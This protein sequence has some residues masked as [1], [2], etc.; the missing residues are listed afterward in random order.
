[1]RS[2]YGVQQG[3]VGGRRYEQRMNVVARMIREK[4][5]TGR[6]WRRNWRMPPTPTRDP[7]LIQYLLLVPYP[8]T[9]PA[10]LA[11]LVSHLTRF[12][13]AISSRERRQMLARRKKDSGRVKGRKRKGGRWECVVSTESVAERG[14][15]EAKRDEDALSSTTPKS[16]VGELSSRRDRAAAASEL[17]VLS[18]ARSTRQLEALR[19]VGSRETARRRR[20]VPR[21]SLRNSKTLGLLATFISNEEPQTSTIILY[22]CLGPEKTTTYPASSL[23][24][25]SDSESVKTTKLT[26]YFTLASRDEH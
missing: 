18:R 1:M 25:V 9:S 26:S 10:A 8:P 16:I 13:L 23:T 21:W 11:E 24:S 17:S 2:G 22:C 3:G 15:R 5:R 19:R 4:R 7:P 6:G 14:G 12:G 20:D